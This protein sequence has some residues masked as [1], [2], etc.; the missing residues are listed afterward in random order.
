M[1]TERDFRRGCR[2]HP[3]RAWT[4]R[5]GGASLLLL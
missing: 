5:P 2:S 3:R 1:L 4:A